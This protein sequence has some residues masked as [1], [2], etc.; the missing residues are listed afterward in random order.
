MT[1]LFKKKPEEEKRSHRLFIMVTAMEL[2]KIQYAASIRNLTVSEYMRRTALGRKTDI[3][4]ESKIIINLSRTI[5]EL[6]NLHKFFRETGVP[7]QEE[8]MLPVLLE[9]R[10][11]IGMVSDSKSSFQVIRFVHD[12]EKTEINSEY[13]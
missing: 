2:S 12:H 11:A 9:A 5:Q 6:K 1:K 7:P 4:Y 3:D 8:L 10:E 13:T